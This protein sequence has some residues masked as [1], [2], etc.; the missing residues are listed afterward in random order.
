MNRKAPQPPGRG[1]KHGHPLFQ[2]YL[3][4]VPP[5]DLPALRHLLRCPLCQRLAQ[6]VLLEI[7]TIPEPP[8]RRNQRRCRRA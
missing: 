7:P 3:V 1:E 6:L 8:R 5:R 4:D 2:A